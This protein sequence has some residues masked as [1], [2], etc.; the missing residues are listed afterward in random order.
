LVYASEKKSY[1]AAL[2]FVIGFSIWI[3]YGLKTMAFGESVP[4]TISCLAV[5]SWVID[6]ALKNILTKDG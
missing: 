5:T 2:A 3:L 6:S 1:L 4:E